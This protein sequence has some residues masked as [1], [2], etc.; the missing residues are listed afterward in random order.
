MRV[1]TLFYGFAAAKRPGRAK[2]PT[3]LPADDFI[4][5][6]SVLLIER[7]YLPCATKAATVEGKR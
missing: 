6:N 5:H 1:F 2:P 7:V 4:L 3:M